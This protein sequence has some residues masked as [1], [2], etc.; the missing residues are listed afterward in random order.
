MKPYSFLISAFALTVLQTNAA[1]AGPPVTVTFKNI[2]NQTATY[3]PETSNELITK[4]N[5][6]PIPETTVNA[7]SS[8]TYTIQ[9]PTSLDYNH[10]NLR[11]KIGTKSCIY[12][13][14]FVYTPGPDGSKIPK[15]NNKATPSGSATCTIR[16]TRTNPSTHAWSVEITMR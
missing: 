10:A 5:A 4:T 7:N 8:D 2:G 15:W 12:L 6:N 3:T 1:F 16:V 13:S 14:T 9:S 11:Y